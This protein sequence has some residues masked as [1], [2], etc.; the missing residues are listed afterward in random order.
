MVQALLLADAFAAHPGDVAARAATYEAASERE[1][2]PWF[3]V[4]VQ[5]D[6]AGADPAGFGGIGSGDGPGKALAA[7]FVAAMTDPVLGRGFARFWN[8]LA[9]PAEMLGDADVMTRMAEVMADPDAWPVPER[10]GPKRSELL[11]ALAAHATQTTQEAS[12]A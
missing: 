12:V 10:V 7:V 11:A 5:M 8:L 2:E 1:V 6:R 9:T 4:S 3:E